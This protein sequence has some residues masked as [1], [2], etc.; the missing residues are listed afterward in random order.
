MNHSRSFWALR[1]TY[2]KQME[3]LWAQRYEGEGLWGRGKKLATGDFVH[4]AM[5]ANP[6]IPEHLCGGTYR[7][8]RGRKRK[9]RHDGAEL[10]QLSYAERQQRRIARKFGPH[11]E[12][13]A[14]G[15]DEIV[16]TALDRA[17]GTRHS[18]KPRVASSKRGRELRANAALARFD[19]ARR[20]QVAPEETPGLGDEEEE[21][22]TTGSEF[23]WSSDEDSESSESIVQRRKAGRRMTDRE[24]QELVR[25]C[26]DEG[27][28]HEGGREETDELRLLS[29]TPAAF[30]KWASTEVADYHS[31]KGSRHSGLKADG[32]GMDSETGINED[33][34]GRPLVK[35]RRGDSAGPLTKFSVSPPHAPPPPHLAVDVPPVQKNATPPTPAMAVCPI[36]SLENEPSDPTCAAC[37]HVLK[38]GLIKC[39]WRC[40]SDACRGS[41]YINAADAGR[42][43]LCG[44]TKPVGRT[45]I[46][47]G[48]TSAETLRWE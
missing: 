13:N 1:N 9:R 2:A 22:E 38:P 42:C 36:C 6:H 25:V 46:V 21:S 26:G 11:G 41:E 30:P 17:S 40:A 43:G 29:G 23:G 3:A 12:G 48:V 27:E 7:R 20:L 33:D 14:L 19:A 4:D 18:G 47:A 31:T 34:Q 8:R 24:G 44:A 16:R 35:K 10:P 15:D 5:P 37:S 39:H 45:R 28:E 32:L